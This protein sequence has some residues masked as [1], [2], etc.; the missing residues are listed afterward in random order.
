[1]IETDWMQYDIWLN[2]KFHKK[3]KWTSIRKES[4]TPIAQLVPTPRAAYGEWGLSEEIINRASPEAEKVFKFWTEYNQKKFASGGKQRLSEYDPAVVK[5]STTYHRERKAA[6][7]QLLDAPQ[8]E[9]LPELDEGKVDV[10][11]F[12]GGVC[13]RHG[14]V[15]GAENLV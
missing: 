12:V 10:G 15:V 2:L 4:T 7:E 11:H 6:L 13:P 9:I 8:A 5:D 1:M 14:L 3:G